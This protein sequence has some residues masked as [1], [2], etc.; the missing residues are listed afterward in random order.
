MAVIVYFSRKYENFVNG[1]IVHLEKG[2]TEFLAE[3]LH[4]KIQGEI[5]EIVPKKSY[6]IEYQEMIEIAKSEREKELRPEYFPI[7]ESVLNNSQEIFLGF[8][9]WDGS[10]PRIIA[11]FSK[12]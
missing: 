2:N 11:H 1:E 10:F 6:P 4:Q 9:N 7:D 5:M 12:N 8:P 3:K